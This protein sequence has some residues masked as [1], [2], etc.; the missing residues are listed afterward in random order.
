MAVCEAAEERDD[1]I[2]ADWWSLEI[3]GQCEFFISKLWILLEKE[4]YNPVTVRFLFQFLWWRMGEL[5]E[6][7]EGD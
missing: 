2:A 6:V 3:N 5:V 7:I 1:K 4:E